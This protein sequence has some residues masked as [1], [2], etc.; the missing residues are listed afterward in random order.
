MGRTSDA[1]DRILD[2][3]RRLMRTRGYTAVGVAEI[4]AD[5]GVKKGSFY[6]FFD[7]KQA[8]TVEAVGDQWT[9]ERGSLNAAVDGAADPL[10]RLRALVDC[11]IAPQRADHGES[12]AIHGCLYGNLALELSGREP[13]VR[14]RLAEV[15]DEQVEMVARLIDQARDAGRI[16]ADGTGHDLAR[17][18]VAQVEGM[19]LLA[20]VRNDPALLDE[21]RPNTERLLRLT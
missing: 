12:G 14:R 17:A 6:H 19:V 16:G 5:A 21:I 18:L 13:E 15:F 1:R 4:C 20:R 11:L 7:S 9:E 10:D 2:S 3:S 8:L